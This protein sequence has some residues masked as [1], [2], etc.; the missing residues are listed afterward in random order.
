MN[1]I[2]LTIVSMSAL[3]LASCQS[4][5][6]EDESGALASTNDA[7]ILA[8][9]EQFKPIPDGPGN[10]AGIKATPELVEL[11][12][13]LYSDPRLSA[14][15]SIACA[16]CHSMG[17]GGADARPTSL[18]HRW[19]HG[20]RNA[21]TVLNAVY[22]TAQ[23]WDGRAKDLTEQAGGPISNPIEMA[24]PS[25][26]VIPMLKSIPGYA[27]LF[28]RAFPSGKDPIRMAN[29][30]AAIAAY[31]ATLVTPNAPFDHFLKGDA[32]ALKQAE[33]RGLK[34]FI[35]NG[36]AAC[37]SGMNLGGGMYAKFGVASPPPA[38]LLPPGDLGRFAITK[39][40]ADRYSY[41]VPTLR[42]IAL[43]APYFHTGKVWDLNEAVAI[44]ANTQLGKTL[45]Q[46]EVSDI[47]TF[48]KSL[49]GEQPKI[50]VPA[51]P[52]VTGTSTRPV[53]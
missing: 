40:E 18:G 29:V 52:P 21:P 30:Q 43:T 38:E 7:L 44:M 34:S 42:N 39:N 28:A 2:A 24:M 17:L 37:H 48:L 47:V 14:S 32:Q 6:P 11:G 33:R 35:D 27:G 49:T 12:S 50:V 4:P 15:H 1:K 20:G 16:A 51:L 9:R 36:C 23:F 5:S 31:E 25:E 8:A 26:Q 41:K 46:Q 45:P 3:A 13:M 10:V 22:N 19:Q 53:D